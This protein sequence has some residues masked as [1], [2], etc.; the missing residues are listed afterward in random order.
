M[1]VT[2]AC[3]PAYE[4]LLLPAHWLEGQIH[5]QV[6]EGL[7]LEEANIDVTRRESSTEKYNSNEQVIYEKLREKLGR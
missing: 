3:T 7:K 1:K 4:L 6:H 5:C 2:T